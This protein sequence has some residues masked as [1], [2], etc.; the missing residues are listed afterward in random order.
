VR[1]FEPSLFLSV[2]EAAAIVLGTTRVDAWPATFSRSTGDDTVEGELRLVNPDGRDSLAGNIAVLDTPLVADVAY[3]VER[4]GA[5]GQVFLQPGETVYPRAC[6]P[7][8]GA[9]THESIGRKP[10]TPVAIVAGEGCERMR[11]A[12]HRGDRAGLSTRLTEQW[13]RSE[14]LVAGIHGAH[15]P[16]EFV[17]V[18]GSDDRALVS[19]A[20]E[21]HVRRSELARS[22]RVAWWPDRRLG[23]AAGSTWYSDTFAAE[24]DEWCVAHV[25]VGGE[26]GGEAYWMSEA[27]ELCLQAITSAGEPIPKGRRPPREADYSFNQIGVTGLFGGH[28]FPSSVYS[29]AVIHIAQAAIYPFDYTAPLLEMGA[30]VQRYQASA[31]NEID[32]AGVSQ[33]LAQLRRA[34]SAWRSDADTAVRRHPAD[35]VRRRRINTTLRSLAR[36]LV[37]LGF[38]RGERFD[39]DPAVGFSALPRLE[40]ALH[41][42]GTAEPMRSFV[43]TALVREINKVRACARQALALLT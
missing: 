28:A 33:D 7:I 31:G 36:V 6:S 16:D 22:I 11:D 10:R 9:P 1:I 43:R 32:L 34:T 42:A 23:S 21:C 5:L 2:P 40:A 25:S 17:L 39:H 19:V 38:A 27:A 30:A 4:R 14:L 15:D 18:H 13:T 29:H 3:A 35:A 24:I 26:P 8:W 20:R 37:P 12:A 41:I